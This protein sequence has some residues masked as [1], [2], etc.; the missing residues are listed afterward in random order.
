M[1]SPGSRLE[2]YAIDGVIGHGGH[3][4]VFRAHHTDAESRVV[5]LKQLDP[6]HRGAEY[7]RRLQREFDFAWRLTHPQIVTVYDSGTGW[8][9][10]ELLGGGRVTRLESLDDRLSALADVAAA[11]D[12]AHRHGIV[13]C[14]VKPSNILVHSDFAH[15]GAVLVDFGS[16][17]ATTDP[18]VRSERIEASLPYAAPEILRGNVPTAATDEYALACTLVEMVTG[19]PPFVTRTALGLIDAQLNQPVPRPSRRLGRA[20]RIDRTFDAVVAKAMAKDPDGR[21]AS[22]TEL[23]EHAMRAVE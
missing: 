9:T 7:V 20:G 8:L 18:H 14:D 11:L 5:A 13:H 3:A 4:T 10:M 6:D 19:K 1:S 12:H 2:D 23:M 16:A 22:C 21:Y 15:G 17:R